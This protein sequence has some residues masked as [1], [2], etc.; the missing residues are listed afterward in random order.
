MR[1]ILNYMRQMLNY[2]R[3]ML[4]P[5]ASDAQLLSGGR[6]V[7]KCSKQYVQNV[8]NIQYVQ[9]YCGAPA[10]KYKQYWHPK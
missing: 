6:R 5:H 7:R 9:K 1:Q 10:P 2:M 8:Q 4:K 3:Q